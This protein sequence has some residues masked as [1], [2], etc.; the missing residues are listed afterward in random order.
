MVKLRH[1]EIHLLKVTKPLRGKLR[2]KSGKFRLYAFKNNKNQTLPVSS[3]PPHKHTAPSLTP[4]II[5]T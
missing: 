2:L 4:S 1:K 3:P 5:E